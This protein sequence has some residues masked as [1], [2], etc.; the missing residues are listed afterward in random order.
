MNHQKTGRIHLYP[1]DPDLVTAGRL[2]TAA[3]EDDHAVLEVDKGLDRS[4]PLIGE[5]L[6]PHLL[7]IIGIA[8]RH[9]LPELEA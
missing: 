5:Y 1:D 4:R 6:G 2:N 9:L 7:K 3:D 8:D